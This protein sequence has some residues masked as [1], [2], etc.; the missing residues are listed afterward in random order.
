M[1]LLKRNIFY[2]ILSGLLALS[3]KANAGLYGFDL[4]N[5]YTAEEKT[6]TMDY[7]P[8]SIKNYRALMRDNLLMLIDY[9]RNHNPNF[10][11]ISHEGQYL[12]NKSKWEYDLDGY[13][14]VQSNFNGAKDPFFLFNTPLPVE[15]IEHTPAHRYLNAI[16]AVVLNNFYCGNGIEHDITINHNLGFISIEECSNNEELDKAIIR[17]LLDHKIIYAFT[18]PKVAFQDLSSQ[19]LINDSANNIN[20]VSEA[21]NISFLLN[22]KLYDTKE[23]MI[24]AISNSNLDVIVISPIFHNKNP[25]TPEDIKRMQIKRNGAT[26][27]ILAQINVSEVSSNDY[28]WKSNWRV[29]NPSWIVRPSFNSHNHYITKY[30]HPEWRK[31][32]SRHFKNIVIS[33]YNGVFFTGIENNQYFEHLTP[34][35]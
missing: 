8:D 22:D 32:L 31:I 27:L 14:Q 6:L 23:H 24:R 34:L 12:L 26:R 29:G 30:W 13:N 16:N 35:E 5:P 20:T 11:V 10:Q 9:A 2:S 15:P 25:F 19:P 17:S 33:G 1:L 28:F 4:V 7:L 18:N 21:K 3:F